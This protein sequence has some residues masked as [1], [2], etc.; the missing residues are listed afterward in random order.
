MSIPHHPQYR[1]LANRAHQCTLMDTLGELERT[2][3]AQRNCQNT[4]TESELE[5][6]YGDL[7]ESKLD[8][9]ILTMAGHC[10]TFSATISDGAVKLRR[11]LA[12][13]R[14]EKERRRSKSWLQE[15]HTSMN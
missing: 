10:K 6:K 4:L 5:K 13:L 3:D 1:A 15:V 9:D 11:K 2:I 14:A 8:E 7:S 12:E